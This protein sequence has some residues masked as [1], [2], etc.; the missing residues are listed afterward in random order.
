MEITDAR[1][2]RENMATADKAKLKFNVFQIRE[3]LVGIRLEDMAMLTHML[4]G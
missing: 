4:Y 3:E 1:P 2:L